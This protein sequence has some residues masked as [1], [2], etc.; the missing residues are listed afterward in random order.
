MPMEPVYCVLVA[1]GWIRK[2]NVWFFRRASIKIH[3]GIYVKYI[4]ERNEASSL[5][6]EY[7]LCM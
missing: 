3:T 5:C 2:R 1:G 7:V 4:S 6:N